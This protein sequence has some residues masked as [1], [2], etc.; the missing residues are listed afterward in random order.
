M[1]P[2][3]PF[4]TSLKRLLVVVLDQSRTSNAERACEPRCFV[5]Q[6]LV[7]PAIKR[8]NATDFATVDD[9]PGNFGFA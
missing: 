8:T 2:R 1:Q 6:L 4:R 3:R 7:S 9:A 5:D